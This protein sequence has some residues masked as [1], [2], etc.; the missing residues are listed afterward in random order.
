MATGLADPLIAFNAIFPGRR[1]GRCGTGLVI[2]SEYY[3]GIE[4]KKPLGNFFFE[5]KT[6]YR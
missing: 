5:R 4:P 1:V 6:P 3:F 2:A